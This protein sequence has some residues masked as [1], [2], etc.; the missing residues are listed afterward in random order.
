MR[1]RCMSL[2]FAKLL[3][4]WLSKV[5]LLL[6]SPARCAARASSPTARVFEAKKALDTERVYSTSLLVYFE[7]SRVLVTASSMG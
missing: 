1:S 3:T 6:A 4:T 2:I 5:V 7:A